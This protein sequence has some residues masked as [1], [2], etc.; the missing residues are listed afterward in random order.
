MSQLTMIEELSLNAYPG[1]QML[2]DEAARTWVTQNIPRAEVL[3]V[4]AVGEGRYRASFTVR[5]ADGNP[6]SGVVV[7]QNGPD[8]AVY[9]ANLQIDGLSGDL[10][11]EGALPAEAV[12]MFGTFV[13]TLRPQMND[14]L[15]PTPT[16]GS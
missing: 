15:T 11:T 5:D 3:T 7:M 9:A 16:P 12:Q 8:G 6:R 14:A 4:G 1:V 10:L 13:V 2:G